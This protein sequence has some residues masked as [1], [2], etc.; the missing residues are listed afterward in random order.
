MK[1]PLV[2]PIASIVV[3]L[4]LALVVLGAKWSLIEHYAGPGPFGDQ[5][6]AE[7]E[8]LYL[9]AV[10]G[11]FDWRVLFKPHNEHRIVLTRL[12]D[13]VLFRLG[14]NRHD[15]KLQMVVDALLHA[16]FFGV[17]AV[18]LTRSGSQQAILP[19]VVLLVVLG[20]APVS[21]ENTLWGFQS[22]VYFVLL[23]WLGALWGM[24]EHD[25]PSWRWFAGL[26]CGVCAVLSFGPGSLVGGAMLVGA[27]VE[28]KR[29]CPISSVTGANVA[30][31]LVLLTMGVMLRVHVEKH[32]LLHAPDFWT[33]LQS[34]IRLAGW[35]VEFIGPVGIVLW[36]PSFVLLL[37]LLGGRCPWTRQVKIAVSF[38]AL[39]AAVIGATSLMRGQVVVS[40]GIAPRYCD[41]LAFGVIG[42]FVALDAVLRNG[43]VA[44]RRSIV[45]LFCWLFLAVVGL[46][47]HG[48]HNFRT[49]LPFWRASLEEQATRIRAF[50][51][52]PDR[53]SILE[54]RGL[55][56]IGYPDPERL[57]RI[58]SCESVETV[59][60]IE[61]IGTEN[62]SELST[63]GILAR[64]AM[65][66]GTP[67]T[68]LGGVLLVVGLSAN[69]RFWRNRRNVA[70]RI[71]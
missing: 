11:E 7:V 54:G 61:V 70:D 15:P 31:G 29:R 65:T 18:W 10:V 26:V 21:Y 16:V 20:V 22:Q 38:V 42:N 34:G 66:R 19:T 52:E 58:L 45:F 62:G 53:F 41:I 50:V 46:G 32:D 40:D 35:P 49:V 51:E 68:M 30:A 69:R 59:L 43:K 24:N 48:L 25:F 8:E 2:P 33:F 27:I 55:W 39:A 1:R 12:L 3:A 5:W 4:G 23:F 47:A 44:G 71:E 36:I 14:G 6:K 17:V 63:A 9:P 28:W 37:Q 64:G 56:E 67:V 60:P 13:C 57:A